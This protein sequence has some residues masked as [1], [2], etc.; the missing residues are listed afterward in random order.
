ML[1]RRLTAM[2]CSVVALGLTATGCGGSDSAG[3][4]TQKKTGEVTFWSFVKGSDKVAAAFNRTHPDIKVKFETVP[5]GQEYYS[6]LS[7]AVKAGTVPDVAVVEYPQLPEFATQG[8]LESLDTTLGPLVDKH[9]PAPVRRLV[10]LGGRTWGVPRDAAPL[11]L[12]YR[13]DF[14]KAHKI[15][16]PRTWDAYRNMT[17]RVKKADPKA[18]GG[19]LYTDN[20]GLLSALTWQAG[21]TWFATKKDAWKVSLDDAPSKKVADYW[22]DLARKDLV[23]S[24]STLDP[25]WTSVQQNRTVAYV[26][27]SWCAG[28]QQATV[29]DQAGK[30]SVAPVPTWDGKP[31]SAMY[32]GST[33]VVPKGARNSG[34]AAEFIKWITTD[35]AGMKA[36]VSDGTS[37]MFPADPSL[38]P[39]TKKAFPTDYFG[40]QDVYAVGSESYDAVV[41]GWT[42]GPVMGTTNTAIVDRLPKVAEGDVTLAD[43]LDGAQKATVKDIEHR[44]MTLAP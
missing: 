44:G 7:N 3:S 8:K 13:N 38:V 31:A 16:V 19:V 11:M 29:A 35:P 25:F 6:K 37:S 36:W 17:E 42:W 43:V 22:G 9:F 12:Y 20:P 15:D 18:R 2:A 32:G 26:C 5:S 4:A 27:A 33:F 41:P 1:R 23:S 24:L 28:A 34:A 21:A 40:G 10:Q 30:W 14:F 39:V